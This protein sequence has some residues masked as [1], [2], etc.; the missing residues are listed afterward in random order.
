VQFSKG[1]VEAQAEVVVAGLCS[2]RPGPQEGIWGEAKGVPS[3]SLERHLSRLSGFLL[4]LQ[5]KAWGL[6]GYSSW[7]RA[8]ERG[9]LVGWAVLA[10]V[11]FLPH[12]WPLVGGGG[13]EQKF[14]KN[15][16]KKER[17]WGTS[18]DPRLC[19]NRHLPIT[20]D[21]VCGLL[22]V[23]HPVPTSLGFWSVPSKM[24]PR[25]PHWAG[26]RGTLGRPGNQAC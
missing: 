14:L 5:R 12:W 26:S 23:A 3:R 9:I 1:E 13:E 25:K 22:P 20:L 18:G 19:E 17:G 8:Q 24:S 16:A 4:S 11:H 6:P 21:S 15:P 10:L 7:P 2:R